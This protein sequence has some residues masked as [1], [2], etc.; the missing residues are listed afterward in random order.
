[1]SKVRAWLQLFRVPN[2]LTVPGDPLAGFL[3]ATGGRLDARAVAPL[4]ACLCLYAAGLVLNDLADHKEDERER[5]KRP[6]PSGAISRGAAVLVSG[7][8]IIFGL[9]LCIIAGP[10]VAL[11]GFGLLLGII[12]YDFFTKKIAV[13]GALNMGVC[14]GLSVLVGA[15]A[16]MGP[17]LNMISTGLAL[18]PL[19]SAFA[20]PFYA[21]A[22]I[23]HRLFIFALAAALI[24]AVYIAAVTNLARYETQPAYPKFPRFLPLAAIFFGYIILKQGTGTLFRDPSPTVWVI[25]IFMGATLTSQLMK[26]PPPFLPPRIGGFIRILPIMQA[27]LCVAP[28]VAGPLPKTPESLICAGVLLACVP[29]HAWLARKFYAS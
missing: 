1:M 17:D 25:A 16:G 7:N 2:L 3:L 14:R 10:P 9:G 24:I 26:D 18:E 13:I 20:L 21:L 6:L 23:G 29:L 22:P 27:A 12:L 11:M 8:L 19:S 5:P 28:S 4:V 15:A